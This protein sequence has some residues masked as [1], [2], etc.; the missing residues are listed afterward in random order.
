MI[1]YLYLLHS[2]LEAFIKWLREHPP[3]DEKK[4]DETS[5]DAKVEGVWDPITKQWQRP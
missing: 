5:T 3:E 2:L 1:R 4:E